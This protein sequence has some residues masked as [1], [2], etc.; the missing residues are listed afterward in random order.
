MKM[1]LHLHFP[2]EKHG[3]IIN[4]QICRY[5]ARNYWVKFDELHSELYYSDPCRFGTPSVILER[6]DITASTL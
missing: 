4:N 6:T 2:L 3:K 5:F 1:L